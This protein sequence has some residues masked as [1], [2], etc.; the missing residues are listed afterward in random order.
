MRAM[1]AKAVADTWQSHET[2]AQGTSLP[3]LVRYACLAASS[4]NTQPWRFDLDQDAVLI[5]PD[6]TRR[7]PAVD[8]DNH[9]LYASLGCAAENFIIAAQATRRS[10]EATYDESSTG[11]RLR[12]QDLT[13]GESPLL[14][15]I[16]IR[17]CTRSIYD[18]KPLS[19]DEQRV[20]EAVV[21]DAGVGIAL[22]TSDRQKA[23]VADYV[24]QGNRIQFAD[25]AW[26]AELQSWIRFDAEH[27][28]RSGDGLY[29]PVMGNPDVPRWLGRMFM[30]L[31]FSADA[32]SRKDRR[33]ILS[34]SAIAVIHSA[35]NDPQHWIAAGRSYQRLALHA[36]ALDLRTA[37][38]NQ[39]VEVG[40]LRPQ[41]ARYL[42]IGNRRPDLVIRI[43]HAP[44]GPRSLRRPVADVLDR[45]RCSNHQR[46]R[47]RQ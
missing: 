30:K 17:Q 23:E 10:T 18:G 21:P 13:R 29:G 6:F 42:G 15:A 19:T 40:A 41:F 31:G 2:L 33:S 36:A 35:R 25:A 46:T 47:T 34:S 27:A 20:I 3:E 5:R 26:T 38:I 32:Q 37:F 12:L 45:S 39:P 43:G 16:F 28:V 22:L 8:P 11:I 9:H 7:C 24:A 14:K 1:Y 4:H 44:L